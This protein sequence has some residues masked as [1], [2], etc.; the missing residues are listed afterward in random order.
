MVDWP[1]AETLRQKDMVEENCSAHG[2]WETDRKTGRGQGQKYLSGSC[3][4]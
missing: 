4:Q 2:S 1:K 3:P